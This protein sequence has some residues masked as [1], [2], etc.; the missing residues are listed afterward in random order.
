MRP[1]VRVHTAD[2]EVNAGSLWTQFHAELRSFLMARVASEATADDILQ[3]AFLRAHEHLVSG[4]VLEKPR[5]WLY[6]I[7]RNLVVD[8]HRRTSRERALA[9]NV[10]LEPAIEA[11]PSAVDMDDAAF[12]VVARSLPLF[13][14]HLE[15]PYREA[16]QMTELEGLTQAEAA[17]RAGVSLPGMKSRVQRARKQVHAALTQCCE[18]DVDARGHMTACTRRAT[19]DPCCAGS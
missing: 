1:A 17:R 19:A 14:D 8:A 15:S 13:I 18:F 5:A 6:Q 2:M 4:D 11:V 9:R 3:N 7:V 10:A 16:L 12:E